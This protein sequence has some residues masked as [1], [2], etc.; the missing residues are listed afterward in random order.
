M[1]IGDFNTLHTAFSIL[2]FSLSKIILVLF[3]FD[4]SF[5]NFAITLSIILSSIEFNLSVRR[6]FY[7]V[8]HFSPTTFSEL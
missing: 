1:R 7:R 4:K 6:L 5:V 2:F 3:Y 8:F